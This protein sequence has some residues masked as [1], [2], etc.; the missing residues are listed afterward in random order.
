VTGAP[1]ALFIFNR[2]DATKQV[3]EAIRRAEPSLLMIVADGP[4]PERDGEADLVAATRAVATAVDWPCEVRT[5]FAERN[6]GCRRR[7]RSGLDWV[8]G[9]VDRAIVLEDDCVAHPDFFTFCDAMLGTFATDRRIGAVTGDNFQGGHRRGTGSCY[10]SKYLH[11]WGWATWAD[12][13]N[14][15]RS[16]TGDDPGWLADGSWAAAH[17]DGVERAYWKRRLRGVAD[18]SNDTWDYDWVAYGWSKGWLT[19]TPVTNLVEN[20]GFGDDA[21][22]T[23]GLGDVPRA[24][25][26]PADVTETPPVERD[27]VADRYTFD[28]HYG[29][30]A[31]RARR[32]PVGFARWAI[33]RARPSG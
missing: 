5:E 7:L 20:I 13:W 11:V 27:V 17:D 24:V 4:R 12:R 21:T 10:L 8:F 30:D 29:G 33:G 18:G 14:E 28:H 15:F 3:M 32:R 1:V 26:L 31:F 16:A 25:G 9:Q 6:L 19:V 22:H 2:P 23:T